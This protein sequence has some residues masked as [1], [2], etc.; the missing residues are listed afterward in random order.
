MNG[1]NDIPAGRES[2]VATGLAGVDVAF[3]PADLFW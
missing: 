1:S 2:G 3:V